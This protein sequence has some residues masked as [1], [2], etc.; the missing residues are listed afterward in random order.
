MQYDLF[1]SY[2]RKDNAANRVT[3][4]KEKIEA[5]YL[6]FANEELKCFF[7]KYEIQGMEDWQHRLLQSLRDS[8]LL[9]LILSP[10]YLSSPYCEWEVVEYLKY[11]YSRAVQGEG[12]AQIYF[13][14]IPGL[15]GPD[16]KERAKAWV[17]KISRRERIDLRPWHD[18]GSGSLKNID[19]KNRLEELKRSLHKRIIRMRRIAD[20][21]G[22]LPAPNAR[23]VGRGREMR[24]LHE[25]VGL[26]KFGVLTAVHGM[27]GLGKT[28]IAFQYAYAYADFYPGGRWQIGCANETNLASVLKKLDLDLKITFTEDEKKDDIRGAK[29]ILNELEALAVKGAE[30]QTGVKKHKPAV[31]LLLDNVDHAELIQPSNSDLI[32]GKEWLKVLVTTRM[33]PE[34]LGADETRQSLLT[35]DELPFDDALSLIE[36]YQPG[37]RFR[38]EDEKVKAGEIV[39]LLAGFTLAVE[40]AALY[41]YERKGQITCAAFLE[42]LKKEGGIGGVDIAGT[43]TKTAINHTKLIS[44][45]LTPTLD[46]LSQVEILILS[47]ASLLPPDSIPVPWLRAMVIKEYPEFE[48]DAE[49]G[50]DDPWLSSI[51][52]LFSL[53]L[54]QI[55]DLNDAGFV[56][57]IVR[58][59]RLVQEL[60]KIRT[61]ETGE[62]LQTNLIDYVKSRSEFLWDGWI[63]KE[64][65]WEIKPIS[66]CA[67][68]WMRREI[69]DAAYI[70]NQIHN[71]IYQLGFYSE[72]KELLTKALVIDEQNYEPS[73]PDLAIRYSSLAVVEKDLGNLKEAKELLTKAIVIDEQNYEPNHPTLA[74]DYSNL[75]M[76]E[77]ALGNLKEAKELLTKAIGIDEQ[78]YEPNH[79]HL[80]ILYSN[81]ATLE[82]ALENLKEAKELL[83]KAIVIDE[84][85]YEPNHP[86]KA[87]GY[88]NLALVE[89]DLGNLK[90]A[91]ELLKKA[92]VIDEQNY[93]PNH[94][95]LA[96]LYSNLATVEQD[97]GNLKEA[98]ILFRKALEILKFSLPPGHPYTINS[99][100]FLADLL[101]KTGQGE[102][103]KEL[104]FRSLEYESENQGP[105]VIRNRAIEYYK[106]GVYNKAELIFNR[107]LKEGFELTSIHSHLARICLMT[108]RLS[109]VKEHINESWKNYKDAKPYIICRIIWFQI[110]FGLL[111]CKP[112]QKYLGQLKSVLQ[113]DDA[114]ME[115]TMEPVLDHLKPKLKEE[116]HALLTALVAALSDKQKITVLNNFPEWRDAK[117]EEIN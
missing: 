20:A 87:I 106:L 45:T 46:I 100:T 48:K 90:E 4:L 108:D 75:A 21:P 105:T 95:H 63:K 57:R 115:W 103:A 70:A 84:Q 86:S 59:H 68:F 10:N 79:P 38:N 3:E 92:I 93:E 49:A 77:Q 15:D 99:Y 7:D 24:L 98:E 8:H 80:A 85:N 12:V 82:R 11:E 9:L 17:E 96:I 44:A 54:L 102:E 23:F 107:L 37:G 104:R 71:S 33:G 67:M 30:T 35:I 32:S 65:R 39:K 55:M 1:I 18:E 91:K 52:H 64:Y 117:P 58:I 109:E 26:G 6:A 56:P 42:L 41:L 101:E 5:D 28:A 31:L 89:Q 97:L 110:T 34:E 19:V 61:K 51:N 73:H 60:I 94:P 112:I 40:V 81:L 50:L 29:R 2:S 113:K 78:N 111:E 53:R 25:S 36:S 88:S 62:N 116:D 16:F 83:T 27:G 22:N 13:M 114:S 76:V 43:K 47:Y 14:E 66:L 69:K 74:R 72:A